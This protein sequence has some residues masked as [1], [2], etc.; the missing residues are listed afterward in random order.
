MLY[1]VT[2]TITLAENHVSHS[3]STKTLIQPHHYI[4][5]L[6]RSQSLDKGEN[7]MHNK[8]G[9]LTNVKWELS[10]CEYLGGEA[11]SQGQK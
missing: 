3:R 2:V 11:G 10:Q 1:T 8:T 9:L 5:V 6:H 4:T 7:V